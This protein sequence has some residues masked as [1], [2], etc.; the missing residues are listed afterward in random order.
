MSQRSFVLSRQSSDRSLKSAHVVLTRRSG[1]GWAGRSPSA[2]SPA[3]D[4][5]KDRSA[6]NSLRA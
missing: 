2:A 6:G 5:S 1:L 3:A 4:V